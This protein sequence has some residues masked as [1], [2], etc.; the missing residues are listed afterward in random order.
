MREDEA[1]DTSLDGDPSRL[2]GCGV[3]GLLGPLQLISA[4]GGLVNQEIGPFGRLDY[5]EM[6]SGISGIDQAA[7]LPR[8]SHQVGRCK[9][10]PVLE[11]HR[12]TFVQPAPKRSL[13]NPELPGAVRVKAPQP[14]VL[15]QSE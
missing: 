1:A 2:R 10:L 14:R 7:P 5:P 6:R 12:L 15:N 11:R 4:E 8:R 3:T 9:G 13:W